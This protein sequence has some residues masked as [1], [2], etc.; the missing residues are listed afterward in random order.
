MEKLA[1]PGEGGVY[2][3]SLSTITY[4]VVVYG[5][6]E[7]ADTLPLF[8]FYPYMYSVVLRLLCSNIHA[9]HTYTTAKMGTAAKKYFMF[10]CLAEKLLC[11]QLVSY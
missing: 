9:M 7:R 4:K 3:R 2:A 5:P 8:L 11:I 6:A 1:Q 10:M